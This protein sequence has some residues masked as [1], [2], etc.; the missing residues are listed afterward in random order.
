[1]WS[2]KPLMY[3]SLNNQLRKK[4]VKLAHRFYGFSALSINNQQKKLTG[5][6]HSLQ[7]FFATRWYHV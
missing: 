1:M 6:D 5:S 7:D 2:F 4:S 3:S